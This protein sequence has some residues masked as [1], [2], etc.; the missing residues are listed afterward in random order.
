MVGWLGA[1]TSVCQEV[2]A[3]LGALSGTMSVGL[4]YWHKLSHKDPEHH[5]QHPSKDQQPGCSQQY[6][7]S[8]SLSLTP[9]SAHP[10]LPCPPPPSPGQKGE[11]NRA[12]H[13]QRRPSPSP[14]LQ[15]GLAPSE[16]ITTLRGRNHGAGRGGRR[17]GARKGGAAC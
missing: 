14:Q 1:P 10:R 2:C 6:P 16:A 13:K 17:E 8:L 7:H 4:A 5:H 9:A 12:S 3:P 11:E 15:L